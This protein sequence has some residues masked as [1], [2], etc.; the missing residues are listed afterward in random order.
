MKPNERWERIEKLY[1]A[2]LERPPGERAAFLEEACAGDEGLR[3][4]LESLLAHR[5]RAASFLAAPVVDWPVGT[6]GE[7]SVPALGDE[8]SSMVG[9]TIAHYKVLE[10]LGK[11][12]MGEVWKARD[13]KLG[14]EVAIK[15]LPEEFARDEER[16]ARFKREAKLLASLNHPNVAAIYGLEEDNRTRFLVLELV[17]GETLAE[18]LKSGPIPVEESLGLALQIAEALEAAHEKGVIHRDLKPGNI[19]VTPAGK[20][21][22]LD[23]GL[24]KTLVTSD[25]EATSTT[26][27]VGTEAGAVLGTPGY[28]SPEQALGQSV[29]ARTD[30]WAL[31]CVLYEMLS[32]AKA[33][34]GNTAARVLS[35]V[36]KSNPDWDR[37]PHN[38]GLRVRA[39]LVRCLEKDSE[40]R[41]LGAVAKKELGELAGR[42]EEGGEAR[43]SGLQTQDPAPR[44][45][46][47]TR[48]VFWRLQPVPWWGYLLAVSF[49]AVQVLTVYLIVWGPSDLAGLDAFFSDGTM[50]VEGVAS[51]TIL[52][53]AGLR[54]GDRV[55]AING[56][57]IRG[58]RDWSAANSNRGLGLRET[59]A[60]SRDGQPF[61]IEVT[62][63][64][65]DWDN[66]LA[67]GYAEYAIRAFGC[68]FLGLLILFLRPQDSI[69]RV[70]AWLMLTLSF[71]FGMPNGWAVPWREL[72]FAAT[73]LLWIPT[74]SRFL[75]EGIF[76]SFFVVFPRR[77][78]ENRWWWVLIWAPVLVTLP[79]RIADFSSTIYTFGAPA[80]VPSL[81]SDVAFIRTIV[82]LVAGVFILLFSYWL[83]ADLNARRRVRVLMWGTALAL[84]GAFARFWMFNVEGAM[85]GART[86]ATSSLTGV[87]ILGFPIAFTYAIARHRLL[88]IHLIVRQGL[89]YGLARGAIL[90]VVPILAGIL[91][92]DLGANREQALASILQDRGWI[93]AG[94]G[95]L[96]LAAYWRRQRWLDT[97]DRRFFR[98]QYDA[99]QVLRQVV[100][101]IRSANHLE[102]VLPRVLAQIEAALHPEFVSVLARGPQ[103][104]EYRA[105]VSLPSGMAPPPLGATGALAGLL[106]A[107]DKPLGVGLADAN[108]LEGYLPQKD[109]EFLRASGIELVVPV[110][111]TPGQTEVLLVLGTK[112]SE[113]PYTHEDRQLLETVAAGLALLTRQQLPVQ[114][115]S[116][117]FGEC[118]VCGTCYDA[119]QSR[120]NK[121]GTDLTIVE[122]P[123]SP[124]G[125]YRLERRLGRGGMGTVYEA[126]DSALDRRVAVKV[127]RDD[128]IGGEAAAGEFRNEARAAAR[129]THPNVVV[130]HDYGVEE[131]VG[132]F[133][134]MELL[135]GGTLR[136]ELKKNER[137]PESTTAEILQGVC[138]AV[139]AA[140]R[141]QLVHRD[142]KPENIFLAEDAELLRTVKILDFGIAKFVRPRQDPEATVSNL[143]TDPGRFVGTPAYASPEQ[144]LAKSPDPG[145]DVWALGVIA[146][147]ALTGVR[148]FTGAPSRE[149]RDAMKAGRFTPICQ[150]LPNA[151]A[152]WQ[153]FFERCFAPEPRERPRSAKAFLEE[154]QRTLG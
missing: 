20:V 107:L 45:R 8:D 59:W 14:R 44:R 38:V 10:K 29:D 35:Q 76:L 42:L 65:A 120:C 72:P 126:T 74:I 132:G 6:F 33:F 124:A 9:K 64:E 78:F 119:S 71:A 68:F 91:V 52:F 135:D 118:R 116:S 54:P 47:W 144:L 150:H 94:V 143:D 25:P 66:R 98:E 32:G 60:V 146:Y 51:G 101:E 16:L 24:A 89:Q 19:K 62:P 123:R 131:S 154:L 70:G 115:G 96:A 50:H 151:P 141:I 111:A 15:T 113:E 87:A 83:V 4:E 104:R 95:G 80:P 109:L 41:P 48:P 93:Y 114:P 102:P 121:D 105:V 130:V 34:D 58:T 99:Q 27:W 22:V 30:I 63:R 138:A 73:L 136:E 103:A 134:V 5:E 53:E 112:R 31:G 13:Q 17:E 90:G 100:G 7:D 122:R 88:D 46:G 84:A 37:L 127:I 18:R 129:L 69:A 117:S 61:E 57:G 125:R 149:W 97:I 23:F 1:Q 11:G 139:E 142:L 106:R 153:S 43:D 26:A 3:R 28:M 86:L 145:W 140:H 39:L 108:W 2:A 12:G 137:L 75:V 21:K 147:E 82:Y 56:R 128:W 85:M 55:V 36:V 67:N 49:L 79:W 81:I 133:L 77:L 110:A 152:G 40:E 148:P 92:F